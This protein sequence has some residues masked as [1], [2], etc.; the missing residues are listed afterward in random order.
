MKDSSEFFKSLFE[1]IGIGIRI[2]DEEGTIVAVNAHYCRL[3]GYSA[4]ELKGKNFTFLIS[5]A[6]REEALRQYREQYRL[7]GQ[8]TN[9]TSWTAMHKRGDDVTVT[10][11]GF[12]LWAEDGKKYRVGMVRKLQNITNTLQLPE[13]EAAVLENVKDSVK[14]V[15]IDGKI[16]YWNRGAT[17]LYGYLEEEVIGKNA[18][19][20]CGGYEFDKV[21]NYFNE[22][23]DTYHLHDWHYHRPDGHDRYIDLSITPLPDEFGEIAAFIFVGRDVSEAFRQKQALR[24]Q[25][26][27]LSSLLESQT[28]FL[29]RLSPQEQYTYSNKAFLTYSGY[30]HELFSALFSEH[31]YPH[32]LDRWHRQKEELLNHK[33]IGLKLELRIRKADNTAGWISWEFVSLWDEAGTLK[34]LQGVGN[35]ITAQKKVEEERD[36]MLG[37]YRAINEELQANEEELRQNLDKTVELVE[38]IRKSEQK[39]K[40]LLENSFE[41][42]ILFDQE[43]YIRY[44]SPSIKNTLGYTPEEMIGKK[45]MFFIHAD[46]KDN[47][48]A[49]LAQ[50]IE[51]PGNKVYIQ[52]RVRKKDGRY[53]WIE[54]YSTNLLEDEHVQGI[55]S[56]FRDITEKLLAEEGLRASE[57]SL[58]MAERIAK[59]G[60]VEFDLLTGNAT[61]SDGI[62]AIYDYDTQK[63]PKEDFTGHPYLHPDDRDKVDELFRSTKDFGPE[64]VKDIARL[65]DEVLHEIESNSFEYRIIS[66]AGKLKY[67]RSNA[68]V[69]RNNRGKPEKFMLTIQDISEERY[70]QHLLDETSKISRVGG[71]EM[72]VESGKVAWTKQAYS[73]FGIPTGEDLTLDKTM[74]F[75][76]PDHQSVIVEAFQSL[77]N[78]GIPFDLEVKMRTAEQKEMWVRLIGEGE[79]VN[80][81]VILAKGTMQDITAIKET[82]A[83]ARE[84][85]D[86]LRL[87]TE[88]AG[89]GIYDWD[90]RRNRLLWDKQMLEIYGIEKE[91]SQGTAEMSY[92]EWKARL[93]PGDPSGD[94]GVLRKSLSQKQVDAEFRIML[95][96]GEIKWIKSYANVFHDDEGNPIRLIGVNWDISPL[97]QIEEVLRSNNTELNKANQELDHFVYSTSH[98]LR[99]PLTSIL[100]IVGLIRAYQDPAAYREYI[101]L[102]EK[103]VHKLDETIREIT[104]YSRN[105]RMEV[106]LELVNF[107]ELIRE[108]IESLS[109]VESAGK[110]H[111]SYISPTDVEFYSDSSRLKMIFTNLL[112]NAIKYADPDK[113]D[114]FIHIELSQKGEG[115]VA[116][117]KDNGIGIA[118]EYQEKIFNMFFRASTRSSGSGLGLY[119]VKEAVQKLEGSIQLQSQQGEGSEFIVS[120]PRLI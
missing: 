83:E 10:I 33:T 99:A 65:P 31:L 2:T 75:Y 59:I 81:K 97:K 104:N 18:D 106:A 62:Y 24:E 36:M 43:G 39:F 101:Q 91:L 47:S 26:Q 19:D 107:D 40:N 117:V 22:G 77:L 95:P 57:A 5:T 46:D 100:G 84:A 66:A 35:D 25:Q 60:N 109:F 115:I 112:S 1:A 53:I 73:L 111:I 51:K 42:I 58:K 80:N 110:I 88:A 11:S 21:M 15:G 45:G 49:L 54:S 64:W 6:Q 38:Y 72:E 56:N 120:L 98:N 61:E 78:K 16:L 12:N 20:Y 67:L 7:E 92:D 27:Y 37:R 102:I 44:A 50:V 114:S 23:H 76:A 63:F 17:E 71:W 9:R 82:E 70:L 3:Y 118:P 89:L 108:V 68:K 74:A 86:R 79:M 94:E 96:S 48:R 90:I 85:A 55:V 87:A 4:E 105:T 113:E 28:N 52:Q 93:Y 29:V 13:L 103:S 8:A 30:G 32:E 34:G 41:A 119:I 14:V 69:L 116:R